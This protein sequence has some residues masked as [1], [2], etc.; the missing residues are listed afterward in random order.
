MRDIRRML[1]QDITIENIAGFEPSHPLRLDGPP[2]RASNTRQSPRPAHR[3]HAHAN[4]GDAAHA[5][6]NRK[7]RP[8]NRRFARA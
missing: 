5:A 4:N 8:N 3:P 1:K 6:K 7:R 2:A